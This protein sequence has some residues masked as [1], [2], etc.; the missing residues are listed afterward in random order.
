LGLFGGKKGSDAEA[1]EAGDGNGK[2]G[3]DAKK[4]GKKGPDFTRDLRKARRFYEHARAVVATGNYDYAIECFVNGLMFDPDNLKVHEE[5]REAAMRRKVSG[6]KG[7][8]IKDQFKF[9]AKS[10][11]E[12]MLKSEYLWSKDPMNPTYAVQVLEAAVK[13]NNEFNEAEGDEIPDGMGDVA[14]WV[15]GLVTEIN[16]TQKRP[17]RTI[18]EKTASM[19]EEIGVFDKAVEAFSRVV[20]QDPSNMQLV[21]RFKDLEAQATMQRARYDE[22]GG[23]RASV[24]DVDKQ[25]ALEADEAIAGTVDQ[26]AASIARLRGEYEENTDDIDRLLKLVRA[27]LQT[28]QEEFE[29]E[30]VK[31]LAEAYE[32]VGQYRLKMRIGDI[33]IKQHNRRIRELKKAFT[34]A[35]TDE[36]KVT[37]QEQFN[38]ARHD[39]LLFELTEFKER[40]KNYPTQMAYKFN[41][42]VCQFHLGDIDSSIASFQE[43]ASDP[44]HRANA[45]QYLGRA[46]LHKE[47]YDEAIDTFHRGIEVHPY[48]DDALALEMKY[49]L[50]KSLA[51]KAERDAS[52]PAAEEAAKVG[53]QIAQIR[54]NYRDIRD[55]I[56]KIRA[57]IARLRSEKGG[58]AAAG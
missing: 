41:L 10:T 34:G 4:R 11:V 51:A 9:K 32:R 12:R 2:A 54:I 38:K 6:G 25:K 7:P 42:G 23:F 14:N 21:K 17:S 53:S 48:D 55:W 26:I 16:D 39:Q 45:L 19:L 3:E 1:P 58:A 20:R 18:Y 40:V 35:K 33:R 15:G 46:F 56:E 57:L 24:K 49:Q 47:W 31:L 22:E 44:K 8:G 52:L 43:A 29:N 27:L 30:A 50:M 36:E 5:L 28:E 37:I 13:A